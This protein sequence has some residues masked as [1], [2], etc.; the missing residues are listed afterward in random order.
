M[1]LLDVH[2]GFN[3]RENKRFSERGEEGDDCVFTIFG[4][5]VHNQWIL[6]FLKV[7]SIVVMFFFVI[8]DCERNKSWF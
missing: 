2:G 7:K 5:P 6:T 3:K 4:R 8:L 1:S